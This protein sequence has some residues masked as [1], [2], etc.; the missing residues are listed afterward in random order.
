MTKSKQHAFVNTISRRK[1]PTSSKNGKNSEEICFNA[2]HS[3]LLEPSN[4]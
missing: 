4:I 1:R 3:C 2:R